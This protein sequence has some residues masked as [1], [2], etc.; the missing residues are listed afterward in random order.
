MVI[1]THIVHIDVGS[2]QTH[3]VLQFQMIRGSKNDPTGNN[4]F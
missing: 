3:K 2:V 4:D 1:T